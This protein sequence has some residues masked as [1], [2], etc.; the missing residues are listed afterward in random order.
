[1]TNQLHTKKEQK[2]QFALLEQVK[3]GNTN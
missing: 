2:R 3:I 1:M